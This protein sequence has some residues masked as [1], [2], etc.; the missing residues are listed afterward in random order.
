MTSLWVNTPRSLVEVYRRFGDIYYIHHVG[1]NLHYT[2]I[3]LKL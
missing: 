3:D 1:D 2:N